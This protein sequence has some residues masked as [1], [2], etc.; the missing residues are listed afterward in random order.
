MAAAEAKRA[1]ASSCSAAVRL[2]TVRSHSR[3]C[4]YKSVAQAEMMP[5]ADITSAGIPPPAAKTSEDS[6]PALVLMASDRRKRGWQKGYGPH[7]FA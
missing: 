4:L 1:D 7:M 5:E 3:L 6:W 2:S